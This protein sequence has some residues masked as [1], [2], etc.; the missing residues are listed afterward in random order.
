M[1]KFF[2]HRPIFA[3]VI[4]LVILIALGFTTWLANKALNVLDRHINP[5]D[6][7]ERP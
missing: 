2:I 4:A 1:S 6:P 3:I 7:D 5:K